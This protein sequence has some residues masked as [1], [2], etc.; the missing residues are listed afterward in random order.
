MRGWN[1]ENVLK[2]SQTCVILQN[3]TVRMKENGDLQKEADER[4][5]IREFYNTNTEISRLSRE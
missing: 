1:L 2:I 5:M 3:K 4:D